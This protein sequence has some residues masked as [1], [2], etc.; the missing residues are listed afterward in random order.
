M[1][2]SLVILTRFFLERYERKNISDMYLF[3]C[4]FKR[5]LQ[6]H[7]SRVFMFT[8]NNIEHMFS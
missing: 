1:Y 8:I 6:K 7:M 4:V 2:R 5:F 3:A